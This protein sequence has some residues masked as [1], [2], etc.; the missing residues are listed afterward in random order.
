MT[1]VNRTV[2]CVRLRPLISNDQN[3]LHQVGKQ[4]AICLQCGADGQSIQM[5]R[6]LY[7]KKQYKFDHVCGPGFSNEEIY[8]LTFKGTVKSVMKKG[9]NGSAIAYGQTGTGKTLT[10]LGN[11]KTP[12]FIQLAASDIFEWIESRKTQGLVTNVISSCYQVYAEHIFDLL[13]TTSLE[14]M[15]PLNIREDPVHGAFIEHITY[16]PT[17]DKEQLLE[18]VSRGFANRVTKRTGQNITSSR[19]HAILRL[20]IDFEVHDDVDY[21]HQSGGTENPAT[22][23]DLDTGMS[24]HSQLTSS[25]DPDEHG[26]YS[27]YVHQGYHISFRPFQAKEIISNATSIVDKIAEDAEKKEVKFR[28]SILTFVDLAGSERIQ[29]SHCTGQQLKEATA[30]NK[31]IST[32]GL[33]IQALSKGSS[34]VPFR[35]SKLTRLLA[36]SL[37][38]NALTVVIACV[39]PSSVNAEETQST[40]Q[41]ALRLV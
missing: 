27:E 26:K 14:L 29:K 19:S 40:L 21:F 23:R 4:P 38:G 36:E 30:I 22:L 1:A 15:R 16:V 25:E 6:D 10:I 11:R 37:S 28:R 41:F 31:S 3:A 39:G 32:L 34:H 7:E 8:K 12:G 9:F 35:D 5:N 33:C 20:F 18:I 13:A 17:S 2:V 24:K